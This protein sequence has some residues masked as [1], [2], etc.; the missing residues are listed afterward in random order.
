MS[1]KIRSETR[2]SNFS[3]I[4]QYIAWSFNYSNKIK[5]IK[6]IQ[7]GKEQLK[8]FSFADN[9]LLCIKDP[10]DSTRDVINISTKLA[11]YKI[12]TEK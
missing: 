12:N 9:M 3:I 5:E 10:L 11:S 6:S 1:T 4:I 2:V 8:L 7:I